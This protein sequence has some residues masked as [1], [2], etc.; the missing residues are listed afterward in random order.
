MGSLKIF[1]RS[2]VILDWI[3]NLSSFFLEIITKLLSLRFEASFKS[4]LNMIL[5][6]IGS[7]LTC[8]ICLNIDNPPNDRTPINTTKTAID[9]KALNSTLSRKLWS[10]F[11]NLVTDF[12]RATLLDGSLNN[13]KIS[14][15][16]TFHDKINIEI[17]EQVSKLTN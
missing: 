17:T 6:S 13:G 7:K 8:C 12:F 16:N 11:P 1:G 5:L 9:P 4:A 2:D 10:K 15:K 14:G 3:F